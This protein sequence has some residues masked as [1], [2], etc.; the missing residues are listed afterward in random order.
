MK[1]IFTNPICQSLFRWLHPDIGVSMAEFFSGKS[2]TTHKVEVFQSLENE[3]LYHY[4]ERKLS[5]QK[6]IDYFI[7]GH[8]HLPLDILL[9]DKKARYINLGEW[10]NFNSY[11]AF[12]GQNMY[13]N[14]F[15]QTKYKATILNG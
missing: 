3:W 4:A 5:E 2:R 9:S 13:L 1:K 15:E 6:D 11:A 12:D 8:R 14:F 10:F 7:F